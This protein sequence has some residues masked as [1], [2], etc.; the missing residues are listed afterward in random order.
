[1]DFQIINMYIAD[2]DFSFCFSIFVLGVDLAAI[3]KMFLLF[4]GNSIVEMCLAMIHFMFIV[5]VFLLFDFCFSLFFF[6]KKISYFTNA[7]THPREKKC[8]EYRNL[9]APVILVYLF[10]DRN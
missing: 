10:I 4:D 7:M 9:L 8:K 6:S 3:P 2:T 1:M 5:L